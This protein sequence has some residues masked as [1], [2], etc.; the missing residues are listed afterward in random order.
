MLD[1]RERAGCGY[2]VPVSAVEFGARASPMEPFVQPVMRMGFCLVLDMM[3]SRA[4]RN[5]WWTIV[6]L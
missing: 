4:V 6:L 1:M 3:V 5:L 2:Y